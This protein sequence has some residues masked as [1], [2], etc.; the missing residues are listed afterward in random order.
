MSQGN[1]VKIIEARRLLVERIASSS[2][3]NRSARLRELLLYLNERVL[4][5]GADEIHEQEVGHKLF[6]RPLDYDTTADNIVRVHAST[7]RKRLEQYFSAEGAEEP[8]ILEIP[9]RNY[10]PIFRERSTPELVPVE[11]PDEVRRVDWRLWV[12]AA[13]AA[14]F[15]ASTAFL[16]LRDRAP[17][18][19]GNAKPAVALFWSQ[20]LRPDSPTDVVLDDSAVGLYQELTGRALSLSEYFDRDYL[21]SVPGSAAAAKLDAQVAS[22]VVLRRHASYASVSFMWKLSQ[23]PEVERRRMT[24][25]F[26]RDYSFRDLKT[27]GA[28]LLGNG[29]NN[30]WIQPFEAKLGLRWE[31]DKDGGVYYPVDTWD[32]G[33]SYRAP[34]PGDAHE[35]YWS[36][37]L[38]PNL[39]GS[40][41]VLIVS[42]TGGSAM[43]AGADFLG[44]DQAIS[45]LRRKLPSS[46]DGAFPYFEA[47]VRI[48]SR[49]TSPRD[50]AVVLCR[51][52]R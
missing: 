40:R 9:K 28:I 46:P 2:Y 20:V 4:E 25:R 7:L 49:G 27:N 29:H 11:A 39:S 23:M 35:S 31:F 26:A 37:S 10:A 44:D 12:L 16:L 30:P 50:A 42:S 13:L 17:K 51:P 14:V 34:G 33:K 15:A 36:V 48:K 47:L 41:N 6:G 22:S 43:N 8:L 52:A 45:G 24:P 38:L 21:R 19:A 1:G 3:F 18:A 32:G 5:D